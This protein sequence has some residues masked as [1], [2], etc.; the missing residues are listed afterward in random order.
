MANDTTS[1]D[2]LPPLHVGDH[3]RD[4]DA[5]EDATLL[6]VGL[7]L[8]RAATAEIDD[9]GTTVADVN[10]DYPAEDPVVEVIYPQRTDA[11]LSEKRKY[12]FP[13]E[14]LE[15]VEPVHDREGEEADTA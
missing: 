11:F 1:N 9:D 14:R 5:D 12:V 10:P 4:R 3:V 6:V 8:S 15:L 7:P 13:R 2:D